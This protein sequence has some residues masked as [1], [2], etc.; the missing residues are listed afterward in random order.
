[1]TGE[2]DAARY[3]STASWLLAIAL[4]IAISTGFQTLWFMGM[5]AMAYFVY[6]APP[7]RLKTR[8]AVSKAVI[9]INSASSF[10][11][12]FALFTG[13]ALH[14]PLVPLLVVLIGFSLGA[15]VIDLKDIEGD[16]KAGIR[17]LSTTLGLRRAQWFLGGSAALTY[18][19]FFWFFRSS[20]FGVALAAAGLLQFVAITRRAYSDSLVILIQD[21]VIACAVISVGTGT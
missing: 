6:S 9:G 10:L 15:H 20:W 11:A 1:M 8:C 14:A 19:V 5:F 7:L 17:N 21:A 4:T 12:G 13:D 18:L 16:R 3:Q 2:V